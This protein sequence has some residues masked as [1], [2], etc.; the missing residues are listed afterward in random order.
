[1]ARQA[2][3]V[4]ARAG[5]VRGEP[6]PRR[7]RHKIRNL[8]YVNLDANRGILRD[9]SE[10]GV[11]SQTLVSVQVGQQ[12]RLSLDLRDP[13]IHIE[14]EG[15]VAWTDGRGQ[16]GVEFVDLQQKSRRLLQ[17]WIFTQLLAAADRAL[18]EENEALLFSNSARPPI[19]LK[20][21]IVAPE[22]PLSLAG[23]TLSAR[24]FAR[25]VDSL[26]LLCAVLLFSVLTLVLTDRLPGW[27]L[28]SALVLGTAAL[29]VLAYWGLFELFFGATPGER[30][31]EMACHDAAS[32]GKKQDQRA[33]FR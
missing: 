14:A 5:R 24:T 19:R 10:F 29:F 18:G 11:A 23:I 17:E 26:V 33:R 13:R 32:A 20:P 22:R 30:L 9:I 6:G 21:Q 27:P 31:A 2:Q 3:T 16:A 8:A 4:S 28:A 12:V 7:Y 25:A 1:M 15:R